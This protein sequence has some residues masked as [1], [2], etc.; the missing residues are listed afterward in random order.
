VANLSGGERRRVAL[1][2]LLLGEARHLLLLD[3]PTNHLMP[4][5]SI[6]S[7]GI[8]PRIHGHRGDP[9]THDRYFLDNVA[10]WI[11]ELDRGRGIP[12]EGN[13]SRRGWKASRSGCQEEA[14]R[15]R[16]LAKRPSPAELEWIRSQP[17]PA[18]PR[19]RPVSRPIDEKLVAES[20]LRPAKPANRR[21]K[22]RSRP[23]ES[24]G[25]TGDRGR[26]PDQERL[27]TKC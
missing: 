17:R 14:R 21:S 12:F 26:Q 8:L 5:V 6:G 20:R 25:N 7:S 18:R 16:A 23:S 10:K 13:Y 15:R 3:E 4:K 27:A 9:V 2:K 24:L 19:A 22:S 1:C 11:L